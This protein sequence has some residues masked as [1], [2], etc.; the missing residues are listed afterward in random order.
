[1]SK[2][3]MA[4]ATL[5]RR[6]GVAH[7]GVAVGGKQRLHTGSL[8][9]LHELVQ[10][11]PD[12]LLRAAE[13]PM[14][15]QRA[16]TKVMAPTASVRKIRSWTLLMGDAQLTLTLDHLGLRRV[17]Q[18]VWVRSR[19]RRPRQAVMGHGGQE[20][21]R[22]TRHRPRRRIRPGPGAT[23]LQH[24]LTEASARPV[25]TSGRARDDTKGHSPAGPACR[26]VP[27]VAGQCSRGR[28]PLARNTGM[29]RD[30]G[31]CPA[32]HRPSGSLAAMYLATDSRQARRHDWP[33]SDR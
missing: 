4:F 14:A 1:M 9:G 12:G 11:L 21:Q 6:R 26:P 5:Y 31:G 24:G 13:P 29:S 23:R 17:E 30:P 27:M 20:Q 18:R 2:W 8:A 33:S 3:R 22:G 28:Q 7:A 19:A 16:L 15:I 10:A 32:P 25:T